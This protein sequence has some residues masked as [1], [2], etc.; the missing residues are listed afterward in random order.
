MSARRYLAAQKAHKQAKKN[1]RLNCWIVSRAK[2][3]FGDG[4]VIRH[5]SQISINMRKQDTVSREVELLLDEIDP[6]C[7]VITKFSRSDNRNTAYSFIWTKWGSVDVTVYLN[8]SSA[9]ACKRVKVGE[10]TVVE[11]VYE[12]QCTD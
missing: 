5:E 3:I 6:V 11:D 9:A 4:A 2:E 1:D 8:E 7:K 10:R 12:L